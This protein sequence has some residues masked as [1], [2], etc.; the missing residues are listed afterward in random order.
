MEM[1][2]NLPR[3]IELVEADLGIKQRQ[4]DPRVNIYSATLPLKMVAYE[5]TK[6]AA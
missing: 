2:S 3:V 4:S 1:S 5:I 6:V